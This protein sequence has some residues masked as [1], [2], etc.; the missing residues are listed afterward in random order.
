MKK[1]MNKIWFIWILLVTVTTVSAQ[2]Q[3]VN[4]KHESSHLLDLTHLRVP[5]LLTK[6][7]WGGVSSSGDRIM[8]NAQ[9]ISLNGKPWIMVAGEMHPVRYSSEQW[10]EQ[11]MKMKAGG[12]N[13]VSVY[14]FWSSH[15]EEEGS[16]VWSGNR[17]IRRFVQLCSRHGM[18]VFLRIG[19]YCNG[20][21]IYGGLPPF[22]KEKGIKFRT[23][24]P[25]YLDYV[26]KLYTQIG[27]QM[28]GLMFKDGGPIVA[29]QLENEFQHAPS[30]WGFKGEGGEQHMLNLKRL[31]ID[32]GL[33]APMYFC[34][35]WGSPVP[36]D[37]MIPGQ[38]G[39]PFM[40]QGNPSGYYTFY[41]AAAR[42]HSNYDALHYPIANIEVGPGMLNVGQWRPVAPPESTE[43]LT[44]IMT[45]IGGNIL[46][47]YM[48]QA[49]THFIGKNG[50]SSV[51]GPQA[52]LSYDWHCPLREFGNSR[53]VYD[54]M[55]PVNFFLSD[56]GDLLA[57]MVTE[58]PANPVTNTNDTTGLRYVARAKG[59]SG[60]LFLNNYQDRLQLPDR[61]NVSFDLKFSDFT[62]R[63]PKQG[64]FTLKHNQS[65]ILPFNLD[66]DG[67]RLN[68]AM[69]QLYTR[70]TSA[71]GR[72]VFVF[73]VPEGFDGS[74]VFDPE[75]LEHVSGTSVKVEKKSGCT[76]VKT[77]PGTSGLIDIKARSGKKFQIMTLT[78]A[79][80]LTLTRQEIFGRQRIVLSENMVVSA[81]G[82]LR[83]SQI[84]ESNLGF[85]VFPA[86]EQKLVADA[87]KMV[88]SDDGAF[89]H[90]S[91]KLPK[92]KPA[93]AIKGLGSAEVKI[94]A[95]PSVLKGINDI[96]LYVDYLGDKAELKHERELLCD[97][98]FDRT[99]WQIGL[100]RFGKKLNDQPLIMT[101]S[102]MQP[103][104]EIVDN[105]EVNSEVIRNK[106]T[107]GDLLVGTYEGASV[108][109]A[110][111]G[112]I[113]SIS[114]LPEYAVWVSEKIEKGE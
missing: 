87:A 29:V 77:E 68:Y 51:W 60:F 32:A 105:M 101:V 93:F 39:Y 62:L 42:K 75:T 9:F 94:S 72:N 106:N 4:L 58:I 92:V 80:A 21:F 73:F 50:N 111:Q 19:P 44:V 43:A 113:N 38:G 11:I 102:P 104:V 31:A 69:A 40:G 8:V 14:V 107:K 61:Q 16:F 37:E 97:D 74:Y 81:E 2:I 63:I 56:F 108:E 24:D 83:V 48:Y 99:G 78:R 33:V 17:D 84:G 18:F 3:P 86:P 76:I 70:T 27:Q 64:G 23:N 34:T 95:K 91:I 28:N 96:F 112:R 110:G 100:K 54:Y 46:G 89:R 26:R 109:G 35:A 20:E 7:G 103:I 49:G 53:P 36:P 22:L 66:M 30:S 45:G 13:T 6:P 90:Y 59:E 47:Y 1:K 5:D 71:D 82:K 98:L 85:S 65:A 15:E 12:L 67:V 57:P 55:K 79:Q 52:S 25:L 10:E 88:A 114:V 41:D